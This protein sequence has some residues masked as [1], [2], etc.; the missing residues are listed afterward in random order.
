MGLIDFHSANK[1]S[2]FAQFK[3]ST[4]KFDWQIIRLLL[5]LMNSQ[6]SSISKRCWF[7][8]TVE[9]NPQHFLSLLCCSPSL[10]K[11]FSLCL[12]LAPSC[13]IPHHDLPGWIS[14]KNLM[15]GMFDCHWLTINVWR[16]FIVSLRRLLTIL[17][18]KGFRSNLLQR[19]VAD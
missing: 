19:Q 5:L 13:L 2:L 1:I 15:I 7:K 9:I 3:S 8:P 6:V 18:L 17:Q 4:K 12:S 11:S 16:H 10:P 14:H